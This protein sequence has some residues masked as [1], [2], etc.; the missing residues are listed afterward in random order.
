MSGPASR[1]EARFHPRLDEIP[2][3]AWNALAPDDNPF[4]DHAFY[5]TVSM[6]HTIEVLLAWRP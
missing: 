5:A 2:A 4:V 6:L 3:Q 1:L